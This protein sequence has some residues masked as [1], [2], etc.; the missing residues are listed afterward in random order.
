MISTQARDWSTEPHRDTGLAPGQITTH[1]LKNAVSMDLTH[2]KFLLKAQIS[3]SKSNPSRVILL[4]CIKQLCQVLCNVMFATSFG[5]FS[6]CVKIH[7]RKF[8]PDV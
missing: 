8:C 1:L 2:L 7:T 3:K 4:C 6:L 5:K